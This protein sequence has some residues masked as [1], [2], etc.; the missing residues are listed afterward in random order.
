MR[1]AVIGGGPAGLYFAALV[2]QLG[3][4]HDITVWERNAPDDTFGFGVV[5]S[6]ETLGGIEHADAAVH[7]AMRAEFARWDDI[8]VHYRGTVTTSGGHGFAA[9]SR[10]RLLGI[11][12]SRCAEL[13]V[14]LHFREEAPADL[15]GYDLVVAA[16]GVNSAMRARYAETF[17]PSVETRRCRYIWLGTDLVFDAFKFYVLETPAGIM[18]IH[19]YP[20]GRDGSTFILEVQEDV[21]QRSFG[22]IAAASLPPGQSDEKSIALIREL[23]ADVLGGH[24]IMANNS[25]WVSFGTVRCET[26]VHDNVV[27]LGDAAHTAHFSIGSGTKLAMEDALA[28]AACLHENEGVAAALKAYELERRPVVTSTQR[29]AQAS[30]EWFENI[31]QYAHQEPPQFAFNILTRSRRVTYDNLRLRDPE[32]AAELDHWFARS[33]GTTSRPPMFQPFKLGSLEL[34]NRIIVSPMDM[35]SAV[36]GAPGD[37]HLVH[38]GSKALGGAGLVMTEM[39][40]VSP[41]GR[42]TPGCGG[43]YTPEQEAAWK[44]I[45]DFVHAQTPARIGVQLGH[46]G[47][48]GSTKLMW[49]G[50]DE[51]LPS[52]NWEVCAPSALPYSERNQVPRELSTT[53]LAEI[54]SQFVAC[55]EAAAR[56]GFDVLEL[57]CA[58][59][60]LLS[61]FLSPLTN[62][63]TDSYGGSLEN[64]L[65]FPLEVFDAVRAAWP[66]ER[67]MTVRI[68]ATDWC[69]GGIDADD[70]VE[71]ARAFAAHGAA[72]IDV[73]TGQVV[74]EE[75]PQYGRSYQ[76]PYADRIR[77]EIGEEYGIAVIAVGAISS[78]DDVNSLILAGRADLCALGR[79]HLYDPQWT[80][81]AAAEQ[82]YPMAW[83]KPF[84][85]GSRKPQ[86]GRSDGP[87]PRLDL[88][89]SGPAGTAHARWRPGASS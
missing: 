84:A 43:L 26:W 4:G 66:A 9:M 12:Q 51:P 22:P 20:Y 74:S 2:K 39:V 83:P 10:K 77:N 62:H 50:I 55:A 6:D 59:G 52:G 29:A 82:G 36:D 85:A 49:D 64:R 65:R 76:T 1:I 69:E 33:L 27:L 42:I 17:R 5:F 32:F 87:E 72:G 70:A 19:G 40:C 16:D 18:Q 25:K 23:C 41:E 58:H 45:V 3:P 37:F 7:D 78:Y 71:I 57:H 38:L 89:R 11:L 14:G 15:S 67:P 30:L 54:R 28:L 48:K 61:S 81:H 68:S 24:R 34:P 75:S 53:D 13:G 60:Y 46:S 73:S 47:R 31:A 8:D 56:A 63:R 80:L 21:W 79:T 86:T 44:R 88:V 35:Y